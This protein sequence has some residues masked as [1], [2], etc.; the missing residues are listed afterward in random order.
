MRFCASAGSFLICSFRNSTS[1]SSWMIS[2]YRQKQPPLGW[3]VVRN[4]RHGSLM[5]SS[6]SSPTAHCTALTMLRSLVDVGDDA[7]AGLVLDVQVAPL[8]PG[9]LVEQVLPRAVGGDRDGVAEEDR[10]GVGRQVRVRVEGL[11]DRR[12]PRSASCPSRR[13]RRR[14][15]AGAPGAPGALPAPSSS[16]CVVAT[17]PGTPRLL[18][19][20]WSGCGSSRSST[21]CA[22]LEMICAG[23]ERL[24]S[25]R[26][27]RG[28]GSRSCP[29][30]TPRR[31]RG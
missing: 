31:R 6:S 12:P 5:S 9:E 21:I 29:T 3:S 10:A 28:A 26:S 7:A 17:L 25:P 22:R 24:C 11:G 4:T 2:G 15:T 1:I 18:Q 13:R 27:A 20:R 14:G 19:C 23:R 16:R 30:S 8:A